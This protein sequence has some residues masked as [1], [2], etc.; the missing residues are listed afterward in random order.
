MNILALGAHPDD[1]EFGC[2]GTLAKYSRKGHAIYLMIM[3]R[4][5]MGG[6]GDERVKEQKEAQ[7]AVWA[8]KVY[9]GDFKDTYPPPQK[10]LI[11]SIEKVISEVSPDIIFINFAEDTHQDHRK[12]AQALSSSARYIKNVLYYEVPSTKKFTPTVFVDIDK[13][14]DVKMQALMSHRSQIMKT[15]I[16]G[17]SILEIARSLA[18]FRG[19]QARMKYAEGFM[20]ERLLINE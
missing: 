13:F 18:N 7:R 10:D 5:E 14:I 3:T 17:L 1:I 15:N 4:G 11:D 8:K 16:E 12:L 9:W 19:I 2:A 6:D 20:P